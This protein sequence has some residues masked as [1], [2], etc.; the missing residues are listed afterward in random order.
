[1]ITHQPPQKNIKLTG[2]ETKN[3]SNF[4]IFQIKTYLIE[5]NLVL[6]LEIL[7]FHSSCSVINKKGQK[8]LSKRNTT[9]EK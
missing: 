6:E 8:V 2:S 7:G 3:R 1:M 5:Q 4:S 9:T